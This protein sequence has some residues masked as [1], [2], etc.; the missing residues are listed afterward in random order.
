M[1]HL[2]M[3][4]QGM[5]EVCEFIWVCGLT[6]QDLA[7]QEPLDLAS[8]YLRMFTMPR[9]EGYH[10]LVLLTERSSAS[11]SLSCLLMVSC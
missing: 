11:S 1:K 2:H 7:W 3:D 5:K 6:R 9:L 8:T 10:T 4:V